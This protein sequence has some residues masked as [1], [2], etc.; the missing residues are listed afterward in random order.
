MEQTFSGA[1]FDKITFVNQ[2]SGLEVT[3]TED[4][5]LD[6]FG[7]AHESQPDSESWIANWSAPKFSG[8]K[9]V[10]FF[11]VLRSEGVEYPTRTFLLI[12]FKGFSGSVFHVEQR[13]GTV[14]FTVPKSIAPPELFAGL[15]ATSTTTPEQ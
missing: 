11:E 9:T 10:P 15:S 8:P 2:G 5:R 3:L 13:V 7:L 14:S 4:H 1:N 6:A 12:G